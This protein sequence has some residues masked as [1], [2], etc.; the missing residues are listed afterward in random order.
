M[1]GQKIRIL[2]HPASFNAHPPETMHKAEPS[3]GLSNFVNETL[4]CV[5]GTSSGTIALIALTSGLFDPEDDGF[6]FLNAVWQ[7]VKILRGRD[8]DAF[9]VAIALLA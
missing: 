2:S 6:A 8:E 3:S 4:L 7:M 1:S 9:T 5:M